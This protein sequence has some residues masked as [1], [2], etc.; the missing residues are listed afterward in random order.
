MKSQN[1]LFLVYLPILVPLLI[2]NSC[3]R[4]V[5]DSIPDYIKAGHINFTSREYAF[6]ADIEIGLSTSA[7]KERIMKYTIKDENQVDLFGYEFSYNALIQKDK[8]QKLCLTNNY[9]LINPS[10]PKRVQRDYFFMALLDSME[11]VL[12]NADEYINYLFSMTKNKEMCSIANWYLK[13]KTISLE[14]D[15]SDLSWSERDT[16][17]IPAKSYIQI[18]P[19]NIESPRVRE[20]VQ[21]DILLLR[22]FSP[23]QKEMVF[24]LMHHRGVYQRGRGNP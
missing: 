4:P 8:L 1:S 12:G 19:A 17:F 10:Q 16:F 24:P 7:F 22:S 20:F 15:V 5:S 11:D 2:I 3:E 21:D 23:Q 6:F 14:H 9:T 13:D 18:K